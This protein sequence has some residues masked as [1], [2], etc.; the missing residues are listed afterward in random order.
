MVEKKFFIFHLWGFIYFN[1]GVDLIYYSLMDTQ[2]MKT[3]DYV[4]IKNHF[5]VGTFF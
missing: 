5:V 4:F 1:I 3:R 2:A